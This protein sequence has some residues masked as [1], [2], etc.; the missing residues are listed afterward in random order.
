MSRIASDYLESVRGPG[1]PR[2]EGVLRERK[3]RV[4]PHTRRTA[5]PPLTP[6]PLPPT[7]STRPSVQTLRP[8]DVDE[9]GR[10][11][12]R[13]VGET[14]IVKGGE[15][16]NAPQGSTI[17]PTAS[18]PTH[19]GPDS[20]PFPGGRGTLPGLAVTPPRGYRDP[21]GASGAFTSASNPSDFTPSPAHLMPPQDSA[22]P[23]RSLRESA[24][25]LA[26]KGPVSRHGP[27]P[28]PEDASPPRGG[29]FRLVAAFSASDLAP[30]REDPRPFYPAPEACPPPRTDKRE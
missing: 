7:G 27:L 12:R 28:A 17:R 24:S 11:W 14:E 15:E 18:T 29:C 19:Q 22:D 26:P 30:P 20:D 23:P 9:R 13:R 21:L 1:L 4:A 5:S 6:L 10:R 2:H 16:I 8:V 3:R 25:P